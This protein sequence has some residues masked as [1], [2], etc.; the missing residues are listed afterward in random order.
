[1]YSRRV[2]HTLGL[3]KIQHINEVGIIMARW[4]CGLEVKSNYAMCEREDTFSNLAVLM[5]ENSSHS[6]QRDRGKGVTVHSG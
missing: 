6:V 2:I 1:M 5:V 4:K 3:T